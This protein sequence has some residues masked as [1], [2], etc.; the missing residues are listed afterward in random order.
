MAEIVSFYSYKGGTGRS[1][2]LSILAIILARK[3][4][5]ITC[6]DFDLQSGGLHT[7]FGLNSKDIH[8]TI[9]DLLTLEEPP[10]IVDAVFDLT[11]HLPSHSDGGKL[12]LLPAVA[13]AEKIRDLLECGRDFP[14]TLGDICSEIANIYDPHFILVDAESGFTELASAS[15]LK[16]NRLICV[17]RPNRQNVDGIRILLDILSTIGSRPI[18]FLVVSQVP[19]RPESANTVNYLQSILGLNRRFDLILP[20]TAELG[21]L[22]N[23]KELSGWHRYANTY[24]AIVDWLEGCAL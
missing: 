2:L 9:L 7:I 3:G 17:L 18:T 11:D 13:E 23:V 21:L 22:E 5:R 20:Y 15:I 8:Y 10:S 12:W 1:L 6:I 14:M 16:A 24:Q 19:D 4:L